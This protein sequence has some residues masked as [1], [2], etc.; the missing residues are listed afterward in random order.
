MNRVGI[1][2]FLHES[3]TFLPVPTT[4]ED[5]AGT[6]LTK[7]ADL[8]RRRGGSHHE[9]GG[10]LARMEEHGLEPAPLMATYAVPS[11]TITRDGF[12]RLIADMVAC[13]QASMPLDGV[14]LAL[15]GATVAEGFPDADGEVTRRFRELLG[16]RI[17]L[18][19]TLDLHAKKP[20]KNN[21]TDINSVC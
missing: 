2:G 9:L 21:L 13:L 1:A 18:I 4:Y 3:N 11:G 19:V 17:P 20:R 16:P 6:T 8:V 7:G 5:F 10:F 12:E 14:L 15:R